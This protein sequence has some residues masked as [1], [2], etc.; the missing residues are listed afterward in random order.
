MK[1]TTTKTYQIHLGKMIW[2]TRIGDF[3]QF[4]GYDMADSNISEDSLKNELELA[5]SKS[6]NVN[7]WTIKVIEE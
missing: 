2:D 3:R 7:G 5:E 1:T 4:D 6:E